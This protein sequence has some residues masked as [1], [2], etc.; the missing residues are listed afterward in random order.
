[1]MT[2]R[3]G[4]WLERYAGQTVIAVGAHPDD[5]EVGMGGTVARMV[6]AGAR[7]LV[8]AVCVPSH[9]AVRVG[10]ARRASEILGSGFLL[11]RDRGC[12]RVED[13][14]TYELVAELDRL[15]M[16]HRPAAF[17]AHGPA[18]RVAEISAPALPAT[19]K[20]RLF[21]RG[22]V[23]AR[24]AV[25]LRAG[26]RQAALRVQCPK[27]PGDEGRSLV[28]LL[29]LGVGLLGMACSSEPRLA[30]Y[31]TRGLALGADNPQLSVS[32]T[33]DD[34]WKPQAEAAA[35]LEAHGLSGTFY[36]NS[37]RL[38]DGSSRPDR[39]SYLSVSDARALQARGH[40]IGAHTLS[41]LR[42][43]TL[44]D[45][46]QA[47]EVH[48]D[49]LQ[50]S[51]LGLDV[52]SLAYPLGDVEADMAPLQG[53]PLPDIVR[54]AGYANA[55]DT[56]GVRLTHCG[57]GAESQ[58]PENPYRVRSVRS[59]DHVPPVA[60]G[61]PALPADTAQTLLGWM[62][63]AASC[64]GGWLPLI[65]HHVREDCSAPGTPSQYCFE[66]A[67]LRE[68]A[69]AL[70]V[71]ERC[72][73]VDGREHCYEISVDPV[74]TTLGA[75]ELAPPPPEVFAARNGS[76]ERTLASGNTEC[77]QHFQSP[78]GTARFGRSTELARTGGAS[79]HMEIS[80]PYLTPAEIRVTRDFGAC[81]VFATEGQPYHFTLYYRA[82]PDA[83]VPTLRFIVYRLTEGYTW[84]R[85]TVGQPF[86]ALRP[87]QWVR[88]T[89]TTRPVPP[90][91]VTLSFGLRL[92]SAGSVHVD[93][94]AVAPAA[95]P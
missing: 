75:A 83:P 91:T 16:E 22:C 26:E 63:S 11:I 13:L 50:L 53:R 85:W 93:D 32:L 94:F 54:E 25:Q 84:E 8:V 35:I 70:A 7:V 1:M 64:G 20:P 80:E 40:E 65:F 69:A 55:R 61:Q 78:G 12:S 76:L 43:T 66:S 71:G 59:V 17:F 30:A 6:A 95:A 73:E 79:E 21:P 5:V 87:G 36:V 15:V 23:R 90:G 27:S 18:G 58:P 88:R 57:P 2:P 81:S 60:S 82:S 10:E 89:F 46:E 19:P 67:E 4:T 24:S 34:T 33:F 44:A 37:P 77:I 68:L 86:S 29:M 42:L 62:D 39:S 56:N 51:R 14:K 28:R 92:E 38:H 74:S 31:D 72:Y 41:H 3:H 48:N 52:R 47:R 45:A 9:F 49:R